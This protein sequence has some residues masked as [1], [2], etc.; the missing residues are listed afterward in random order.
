MTPEEII[1][2]QVDKAVNKMGLDD[3]QALTFIRQVMSTID[4]MPEWNIDENGA[5]M[6]MGYIKKVE[7]PPRY[8]M[9]CISIH[10]PNIETFKCDVVE[11]PESIYNDG[12][13]K[14]NS[15]REN[16]LHN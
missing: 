9:V 11:I 15:K 13:K 2:D 3:H 5:R 10:V 4:G 12:L 8:F 1:E 7:Q 6:R 14:F 16:I